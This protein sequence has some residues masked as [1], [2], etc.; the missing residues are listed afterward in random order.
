MKKLNRQLIKA[1]NWALSGLMASAGFTG[2]VEYGTPYAEFI[3]SGKITDTEHQEL[4]GI[5]VVVP[6]VDHHQRA[7]DNYLPHQHII[8][9]KVCDTVYTKE[10]GNFEYTYTGFPTNDSINVILQFEE[11]A[12]TPRFESDSAKITF[13][14]S[15]L[16]KG[17]GWYKGVAKK[18]IKIQLKKK[19]G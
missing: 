15:D 2:C 12:E 10:N 7:T 8:T 1:I 3:V 19:K 14:S 17:D 18:E 9:D 13:F 4:K 5:R 6:R 11:V 16:R